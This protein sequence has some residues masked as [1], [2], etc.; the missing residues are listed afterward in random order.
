[1]S[2]ITSAIAWVL[3]AVLVLALGAYAARE[4]GVSA[5]EKRVQALWD[6]D[7]AQRSK[8][9][10]KINGEAKAA[11]PVI[12]EKVVTVEKKVY[13]KGETIIK[14]IPVYVTAEADAACTVPLGFVSLYDRANSAA[15]DAQGHA[16]AGADAGRAAAADA[17]QPPEWAAEPSGV[18][19]SRIAAV[20]TANATAYHRL[21][22][23]HAGLVEWIGKSCYLPDLAQ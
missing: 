5:G 4:S 12:I 20:N 8:D 3:A 13:V 1:M 11:E 18:R 2:K 19:L 16:T 22:A 23:R 10:G 9:A 14:E 7:K 15:E 17:V 21:A 6:A